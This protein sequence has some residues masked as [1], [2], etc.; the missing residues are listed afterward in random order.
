[1][2]VAVVN[3][4][5]KVN[6]VESDSIA[7]AY[8]GRGCEITDV[9]DA[10]TVIVNTCTVTGEAEK[11]TRKTV[12]KALRDNPCA[13]LLVT[14]CAATINPAE[15]E[16]M[17]ERVAVV[18]K[19][20]LLDEG[21]HGE[22]LRELSRVGEGFPTRVG[23]KVQDG[24]AHACTYCIVHVAR[25][26]P[27]SKPLA[28]VVEE[29][30]VLEEKGAA[31][32]VLT[33]IDIGSYKSDGVRLAGLLEALLEATE[34]IRIR[35]SSVEPRSLD[36]A[37]IAVI[38]ANKRVCNHLHLPLQSGSS[39][40]LAEMHRPYDRAFFAG[41]AGRI[42]QAIP[43]IALSTDII[44]GFP[45]ETD[46]DFRE[47]LEL[48]REVGFSKIHIFRYSKRAS[49]PAAERTDQVSAEVK[50]ARAHELAQLERELR[51]VYAQTLVGTCETVVMEEANRGTSEHYFTVVTDASFEPGA[52]VEV[53][54]T[55]YEG[56]GIFRA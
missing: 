16:A 6:R 8:M 5:C 55:S 18:D 48:A 11:K 35:I 44:V 26:K 52:A 20:D 24:C 17:D 36:D 2:K 32:V 22:T 25:G 54:L 56:S 10:D 7:L 53:A 49:T 41:L 12:R 45:G 37:A 21:G 42:K 29:V 31:E 13:Q 39:K 40:V 27:W 15:F 33:G 50:E 23:V 34:S 28:Q 43:D 38:A 30:K 19:V 3:L 1:M 4:G 51:D 14:G 46:D 47:T 9:A